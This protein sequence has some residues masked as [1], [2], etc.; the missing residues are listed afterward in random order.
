M[1]VKIIIDNIVLRK[2]KHWMSS[3][4]LPNMNVIRHWT[5][6]SRKLHQNFN[7]KLKAVVHIWNFLHFFL[8]QNNKTLSRKKIYKIVSLF[9]SCF[10]CI[11]RENRNF[12]NG[13]RIVYSLRSLYTIK[14]LFFY[15]FL[16]KVSLIFHCQRLC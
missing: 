3:S 6:Y 8:L 7:F 11:R 4:F 12:H 9:Y 13:S 15:M 1:S 14:Q 16:I 10:F 5:C 2:L